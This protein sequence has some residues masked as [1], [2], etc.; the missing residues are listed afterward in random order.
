MASASA[1]VSGAARFLPAVHI[2]SGFL[3]WTV[4]Q[5]MQPNKPSAL[6]VVFSYSVSAQRTCV[7]TH[8][9]TPKCQQNHNGWADRRMLWAILSSFP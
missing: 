1:P 7:H 4:I 6:Q 2:H 8:E 9:H 3:Q 5:N